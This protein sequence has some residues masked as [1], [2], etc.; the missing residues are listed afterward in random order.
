MSSDTVQIKK[1]WVVRGITVVLHVIVISFMAYLNATLAS[2][3]DLLSY[4]T[5]TQF[6][7]YIKQSEL[8]RVDKMADLQRSLDEILRRVAEIEKVLINQTGKA[9]P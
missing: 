8:R 4:L 3:R 7:E 9:K 2:K 1:E 5:R 6:D